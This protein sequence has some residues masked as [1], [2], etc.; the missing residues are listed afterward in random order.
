MIVWVNGVFGAGRA[1]TVR[2]LLSVLPGSAVFDPEW[3]AAGLRRTL[4][5]AA[6]AAEREPG[7]LL[8]WRRLVPEAVA[9]FHAELEELPGAG[10]LL[11]PMA[12]LRK[13]LRDEIFGGLAA[14]R[15]SVHHVVLDAEETILRSRIEREE[16]EPGALA[17]KLKQL[18]EYRA[19]LDDWLRAD[20][21]VIRTEGLTPRQAAV[22]VAAELASGRAH[23]GIVQDPLPTGDTVA[24]AVL[25]FD[26]EDR[27]LLVDPVYKAGWEFPGGV[28]ESGEAPVAA[29]VR[30]A[31]EELGLSLAPDRLR[32][33]LVDWE[34]HRGPRTG[35]LRL[36]FDGGVLGRAER[37][38]LRLPRAELRGR[39]F[40]SEAEAAGLL[41][42]NKHRRLAAAL[43]ARR[44][45]HPQYAEKGI[46]RK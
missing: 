14:R 36:V 39:R 27:V 12:L 41:P 2:E 24:S 43:A 26:E 45:V 21:A 34:P 9:A 4:P 29:A 23:R 18:G 3:V 40:V 44:G 15:I 8:S 20:A 28:V 11:V 17:R 1:D 6:G 16:A 38:G 46:V 31:R 25:L 32:L 42:A 10:P 5:P 35:G 33:L 37:A 7:E 19:A 22:A 13:D 30:E